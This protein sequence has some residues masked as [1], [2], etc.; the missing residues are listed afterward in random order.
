MRRWRIEQAVL[1]GW[2]AANAWMSWPVL[3]ETEWSRAMAWVIIGVNPLVFMYL[4][5]Q[6]HW[7]KRGA[8]WITWPIVVIVVWLATPMVWLHFRGESIA[9]E[10]FLSGWLGWVFWLSFTVC[11]LMWLVGLV[12]L[13]GGARRR[14]QE[15]V[16]K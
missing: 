16:E 14:E 2:V 10:D 12:F 15:K 4:G 1:A 13:P 7:V 8:G 6:G 5:W 9:S 11:V 3:V